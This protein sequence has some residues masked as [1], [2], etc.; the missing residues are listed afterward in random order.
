MAV[1]VYSWLSLLGQSS[2]IVG[3]ADADELVEVA[4]PRPV[5]VELELDELT[6]AEALVDELAV[7]ELDAEEVSV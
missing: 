5:S 2:G 4:L 3:V 7:D 6:L 1:V